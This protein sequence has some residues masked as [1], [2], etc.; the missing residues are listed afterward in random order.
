MK[1]KAFLEGTLWKVLVSL[2]DT[3][4]GKGM[5]RLLD[6]LQETQHPTGHSASHVNHVLESPA[7]T[8]GFSRMLMYYL[9]ELFNSD[10][11]QLSLYP[12]IH[13]PRYPMSQL[14]NLADGL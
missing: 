3:L 10:M 12:L 11:E 6:Q 8:M 4:S 14:K 2:Q 13:I 5:G 9:H 1:H 7:D